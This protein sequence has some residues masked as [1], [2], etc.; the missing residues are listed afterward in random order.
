MGNG[1]H[2]FQRERETF[3]INSL[4][5]NLHRV[6]ICKLWQVEQV[7]KTFR[8]RFCWAC[9]EFSF[10]FLPFWPCG[11]M[12]CPIYQE[13]TQILMYRV[14]SAV[15]QKSLWL[16]IRTHWRIYSFS[17]PF[18]HITSPICLYTKTQTRSELFILG[19]RS[20]HIGVAVCAF[21]VTVC[22][23]YIH[24]GFPCSPNYN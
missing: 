3:P 23:N 19:I 8:G 5:L 17:L 14:N 22:H 2:T 24:S 21:I 4:W 20:L 11:S 7:R 6:I 16:S 13:W 10:R 1:N 15:L 9:V 12:S 18:G